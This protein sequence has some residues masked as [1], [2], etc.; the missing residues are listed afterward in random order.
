MVSG[1]LSSRSVT[2]L[3]AL[4]LGSTNLKA[5][6]FHA[7]RGCIAEGSV[8]MVYAV[9]ETTPAGI[10]H[11]ELDVGT[12][13]RATVRLIHETCAAG[14]IE[15]GEVDRIAIASQAQTFALLD[16]DGQPLTPFV[17][18][19]DTRGAPYAGEIAASLGR[20]FHSHCSFSSGMAEMALTKVLWMRHDAP[21]TLAGAAHLTLLPSYISSRL[22]GLAVTD[23]NLAAMSGLYSLQRGAWWREA[24]DLCNLSAAQLP[25]IA[26]M[27]APLQAR[28]VCPE[29]AFRETLEIVLAG[30]DQTAGAFGNDCGEGDWVVTLGTALVAYRYAGR[31]P[32]PYSHLGCWGPYPGGGYYELGVRNHGC[33]ALDWARAHLMPG[34]GVEAFVEVAARAAATGRSPTCADAGCFYPAKMATPDAWIGPTGP[35]HR[36]LAVLEGIGFSLRRL[37]FEDLEVTRRPALITAIGGGSRSSFWLQRLADILGCP[38]RRGTGDARTG[39]AALATADAPHFAR[40]L[41]AEAAAHDRPI[42]RPTAAGVKYYQALYES[43]SQNR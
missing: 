5:A 28:H 8:P 15:P 43:W 18:W 11:V 10:S 40:P 4:D 3:L 19:L 22:A 30:N 26:P 25:G 21:D 35:S 6:L 12:I 14:S 16:A 23:A 24:L 27:G 34:A 20:D 31:Q 13:W 7:D 1:D 9:N 29:V 41:L 42:Y 37:I 33:L 2:Y 38:V 17:S 39:A 32:G 36:A